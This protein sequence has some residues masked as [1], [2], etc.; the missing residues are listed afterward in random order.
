MRL[1]AYPLM[2]AAALL[3]AAPS[4][5]AIY[6]GEGQDACPPDAFCITSYDESATIDGNE[7]D[8]PQMYEL[9]SG[10]G[11]EVGSHGSPAV[12]LVAVVGALGAVV[13]LTRRR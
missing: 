2:L 5:L 8:Y 3:V 9:E 11:D 7:T 10:V 6:E 4:A 1:Y 13:L 12:A